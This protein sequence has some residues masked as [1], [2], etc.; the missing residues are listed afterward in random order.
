LKSEVNLSFCLLLGV[1]SRFRQAHMRFC[2]IVLDG[3]PSLLRLLPPSRLLVRHICRAGLRS[4][5]RLQSRFSC[6]LGYTAKTPRLLWGLLVRLRTLRLCRLLGRL[7]RSR[8]LFLS[9]SRAFLIFVLFAR[10]KNV[11]GGLF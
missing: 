5:L 4:L 1:V 9:R 10:F 3:F 7:D 2:G 6:I 11:D 8:R